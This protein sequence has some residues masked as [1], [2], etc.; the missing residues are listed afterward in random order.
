MRRVLFSWIPSVSAWI[1][2]SCTLCCIIEFQTQNPM[3]QNV[4]FCVKNALRQIASCCPG[5]TLFRHLVFCNRISGP[6]S[7]I[8]SSNCCIVIRKYGL[9]KLSDIPSSATRL[10]K[11]PRSSWCFLIGCIHF[12]RFFKFSN[13]I[14][15]RKQRQNYQKLAHPRTCRHHDRPPFLTLIHIQE[16][17]Q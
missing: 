12:R 15:D 17:R 9:N 1:H 14:I 11:S 10:L 6:V 3:H 2:K 7:A 8:N 4:N 16:L 13:T 5:S